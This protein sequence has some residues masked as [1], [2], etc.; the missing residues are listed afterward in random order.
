MKS[1]KKIAIASLFVFGTI[2][3][4][5][6]AYARPF[7]DMFVNGLVSINSF[8]DS[9][10]YLIYAKTID[11]FFFAL[12]FISVYMMGAR[13]AFKEMKK[14]EKAIVLLLGLMTAFL[15]VVAGF[16]V[17]I[18]L[19][20]IHWILYFLLFAFY[21]W[22]LKWMKNKFW[23]FVLAL[24]LTL[25]TIGLFQGMYDYLTV[26]N[27]GGVQLPDIQTPNVN[28][29]GIAGWF[30]GLFGSIGNFFKSFGGSF[31]GINLGAYSPGIP[32]WARNWG[33]TDSSPSTSGTG[34]TPIDT[35]SGGT[36]NG[37]GT[38]SQPKPPTAPQSSGFGKT[39]AANWMWILGAVV[40]IPVILSAIKILKKQS[41]KNKQGR[42]HGDKNSPVQDIISKIEVCIEE[43][44]S[45]LGS[46]NEKG[47]LGTFSKKQVMAGVADVITADLIKLSSKLGT[48]ANLWKDEFHPYFEED[49][50]TAKNLYDNERE[51][52]RCLKELIKTEAKL[53]TSIENDNWNRIVSS[54]LR[55][56]KVN[57]DEMPIQGILNEIKHVA[58]NKAPPD[59]AANAGV[60][61]LVYY[62]A[63][64]E[65]HEEILRKEIANLATEQ[66]IE[67]L[68]HGKF[69][70][71][72]RDH[73]VLRRYIDGEVGIVSQLK[74]R[75]SKQIELLNSLKSCLASASVGHGHGGGHDAGH[76]NA[77]QAT[78]GSGAADADAGAVHSAGRGRTDDAA[79]A[80]SQEQ[81][82]DDFQRDF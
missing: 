67:E 57:G 6:L 42:G 79:R 44:Q 82:I 25:L 47:I 63:D 19:P 37:G 36:G 66:G 43:K 68:V 17:A 52:I 33:R 77:G 69:A 71:F 20:Y 58:G 39:L 48:D 76:D 34:V 30:K 50:K 28:T 22:L 62:I 70:R 65:Q 5:N 73:V 56:V 24:L 3:L 55:S 51:L 61:W 40:V 2:L 29:G 21:M 7:T 10:Q 74:A 38:P 54:V 9:G 32:D 31:S 26:P 72:I 64:F 35:P 80:E 16:S 78:I 81:A 23:R 59:E 53:I 1:R 8:L 41:G 14:P 27:I 4:S 12:L 45:S 13:Y 18:L 60:I 75:I 15:L 49:E 11:F 46:E